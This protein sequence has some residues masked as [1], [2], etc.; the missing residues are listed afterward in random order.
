MSDLYCPDCGTKTLRLIE[1]TDEDVNGEYKE[2]R[3][4]DG[5]EVLVYIVRNDSV[6]PQ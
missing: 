2:V 1:T 4:C 6:N 5:C 3:T